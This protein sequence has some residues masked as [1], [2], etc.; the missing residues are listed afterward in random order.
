MN[1]RKRYLGMFSRV[2]T[3]SPNY[4][5]FNSG[6]HL[7][8]GCGNF[9]RNPF[10]AGVLYGADV[11]PVVPQNLEKINFFRSTGMDFCPL[12][13]SHWIRFPVTILLNI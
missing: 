13:T 10:K 7:D 3:A 12:Q 1:T 5:G 9:A 11:S 2:N 8:V 6:V 4:W